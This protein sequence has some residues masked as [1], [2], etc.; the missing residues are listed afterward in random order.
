MKFSKQELKE[1]CFEDETENF[2]SI[3][4]DLVD[5]S[6]W[7]LHY[8]QVFR[9]KRTGKLYQTT[10]SVGATESQDERPY[11][12]DG[13]EIECQEVRA[14]EVVVTKYEKV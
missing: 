11:E 2:E 6:R 14:V 7:S 10:W 12:Y 5:S 1:L 4:V 9:D 13:D 3:K 8:E